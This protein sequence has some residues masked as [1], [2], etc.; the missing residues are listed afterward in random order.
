MTLQ[1]RTGET[2]HWK[3]DEAGITGWRFRLSPALWCG[4]MLN[5]FAD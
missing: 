3:F 5:P 4:P 1:K 2:T